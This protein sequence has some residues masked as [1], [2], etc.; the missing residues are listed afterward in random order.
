[1][2]EHRTRFLGTYE[3]GIDEKGRMVLP[4]KIRAQLGETAIL[5]KLDDCIGLF[6]P[7]GFDKVAARFEDAL[8]EAEETDDEIAIRKALKALRRFTA[9][10][11]EVTPDQ[12][13]RIVVPAV[14]RSYAGLEG[15]VVTN[16]VLRRAEIWARARWIADED[17]S[18]AEVARTAT[19]RGLTRGR[20]RH[21]A[22]EPE[23]EQ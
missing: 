11:T 10:A 21:R 18:D 3:H 12:Q 4:A 13:G 7:E 19:R 14:L 8:D 9:D 2:A 23:R 5:A 17:E 6:T 1:M 20:D 22:D 16:G 15:E